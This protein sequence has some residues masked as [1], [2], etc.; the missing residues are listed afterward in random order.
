MS[1][2][3][4][5]MRIEPEI[6][7]HTMLMALF[8]EQA[9]VVESDSGDDPWSDEALVEAIVKRGS[10][11]HFRTLLARYKTKVHQITM[12]VL[13]PGLHS[14]AEDAAQEVFL[15]LY[16]KLESFR[17]DC[18]FSTW[19]YRIAINTS[20]D[21]RRRQRKHDA[22]DIESTTVPDSLISSPVSL[23]ERSTLVRV[24]QAINEL[25]ETQRMM[26]Y[27]YYWLELKTREIS[28]I[29]GCPEGTVK[30]YL[31]RAR[32]ALSGQL[33]DLADD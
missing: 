15:K 31:S 12:S 14:Q 1:V 7:L 2:I 10:Q 11:Q 8:A 24:Q 19:L 21:F 27:Q 22:V 29:L 25:P 4:M 17:G 30:V 23:R 32:K 16:Q 9:G 18:K 3:Q 26:V 33:E 6:G 20:I 28:E 13:G 5:T